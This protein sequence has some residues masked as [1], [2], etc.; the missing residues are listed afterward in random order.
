[1]GCLSA[2][3]LGPCWLCSLVP[4]VACCRPLCPPL[5]AGLAHGPDPVG[6]LRWHQRGKPEG[7][8]IEKGSRPLTGTPPTSVGF[9]PV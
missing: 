7:S 3:D 4:A 5:P 2:D 9:L 8:Q 1:M 6:T